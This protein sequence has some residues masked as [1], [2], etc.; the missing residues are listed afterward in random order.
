MAAVFLQLLLLLTA[1]Q[2]AEAQPTVC[3]AIVPV[4]K[5]P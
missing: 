3:S 1:W 5:P 2:A 4:C